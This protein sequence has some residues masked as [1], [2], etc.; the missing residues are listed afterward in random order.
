M[1]ID[2]RLFLKSVL[3]GI[4]IALL[5]FVVAYILLPQTWI[6]QAYLS[7]GLILGT[8]F[9]PV[10]PTKLVYWL[11][12]E[13]GGPAFVLIGFVGAVLFWFLLFAILHYL[14]RTRN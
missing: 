5:L 8:I 7:P 9:L 1:K 4:V 3:F 11:V 13:G 12:P 6:T 2:K 14:W 10:I